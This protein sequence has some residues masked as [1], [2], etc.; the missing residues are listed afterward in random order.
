MS[1]SVSTRAKMNRRRGTGHGSWGGGL[2][3]CLWLVV[4]WRREWRTVQVIRCT[5][6]RRIHILQVTRDSGILRGLEGCHA[7]AI[8]VN[9]IVL[10]R[11]RAIAG[12]AGLAIQGNG[13]GRLSGE[14]SRVAISSCSTRLA[15]EECSTRRLANELSRLPIPHDGLS[16]SWLNDLSRTKRL[17]G[18]SAIEI[19]TRARKVALGCKSRRS[20]VDVAFDHSRWPGVVICCGWVVYQDSGLTTEYARVKVVVVIFL[21]A[22]TH[23]PHQEESEDSKAGKSTG[24]TTNDSGN[25]NGAR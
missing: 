19:W 5:R 8:E 13:V 1:R 12:S 11:M 21:L 7:G 4:E 16:V 14:L 10:S 23:Q 3:S 9:V 15:C 22:A 2:S 24:D 6:Y 17:L 20:T 25:V 18:I